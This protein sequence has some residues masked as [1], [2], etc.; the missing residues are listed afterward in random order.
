M[1]NK[2][3]IK[4]IIALISI[5][6]FNLCIFLFIKVGFDEKLALKINVNID[7]VENYQVFYSVNGEW[8]EDNSTK[9]LYNDLNQDKTLKFLVPTESQYLRIDFGE[10]PTVNTINKI[11]FEYLHKDYELDKSL[12]GQTSSDKSNDIEYIKE[13]EGK[14]ELKSNG[15]DSYY[16]I[17]ISKLKLEQFIEDAQNSYL[18]RYHILLCVLIDL[19][20]I[21]CIRFY[22]HIKEIIIEIFKN[23]KLVLQLAKNDFK[24]RFAGSYL[25]V[26][27]AFVQPIVTVIV[28][29]FVFQMAFKSGNIGDSP[30]ILWL[31]A[32]LV[33]WFFFAEAINSA[34]VSLID[35]SYLVKKVVFNI[36]ILPVV[37]VVSSFFVHVFFV[38]ITLLLFVIYK[39]GIDIYMIQV[40][41]YTFCMFVLVL[42]IVYATSALQVFFRDVGQLVNILLQVGMWMTPIMWQDTMLPENFRVLLYLNPMYYI[43]NGYRDSLIGKVWFWER[44]TESIVFWF[45]AI[46]IFIIGTGIY[47]KLKVHFADVL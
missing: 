38:V 39:Y 23:R 9:S 40:V 15:E 46:M 35:Y 12:F 28:Y 6:I 45:I 19:L 41:Y 44:Q 3:L 13:K 18:F 2:R 8:S 7:T 29:W 21:F 31:V 34:T 25:G 42:G 10:V 20:S 1:K 47:K 4:I 32:G 33:S 43:T 24:T 37:K 36:S 17:D 5:I 14:I 16:I 30:F 22:S 27:W 11:Y 26:I